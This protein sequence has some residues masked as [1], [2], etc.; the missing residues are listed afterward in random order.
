MERDSVGDRLRGNPRGSVAPARSRRPAVRSNYTQ[1]ARLSFEKLISTQEQLTYVIRKLADQAASKKFDGTAERRRGFDPS[2]KPTKAALGFAKS[3]GIDVSPALSSFRPIKRLLRFRPRGGGPPGRRSC[4]DRPPTSSRRYRSRSRCGGPLRP[5]R[6]L[7][8]RRRGPSVL[9]R[10][11][12][13]GTG[14][15]RSPL[16]LAPGAIDLPSRAGLL[17]DARG[18][19]GSRGQ[20]RQDP[21]GPNVTADRREMG[22]GRTAR[23]DRG[24]PRRVPRRSMVA[25]SRRSTY[26]SRGRSSSPR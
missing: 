10:R 11:R 16:L 8:V 23:G 20:E 1:K 7:A 14:D 9:V 25:T 6:V 21:R 3:Q 4:E 22:G 15:V 2:G 24:Q 13:G 17:A 5:P 18:P 19:R 12:H 26:R